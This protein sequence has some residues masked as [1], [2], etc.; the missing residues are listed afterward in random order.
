MEEVEGD[1]GNHIANVT[2][3]EKITSTRGIILANFCIKGYLESIFLKMMGK[4]SYLRSID[5]K[6]FPHA[7][8]LHD[9]KKPKKCDK[10]RMILDA[11]KYEFSQV[12]V[13]VANQVDVGKND[14]NPSSQSS[15][16]DY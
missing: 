6:K 2:M 3:E 16:N 15:K 8:G 12:T 14:W 9:A 7:I 5:S 1:V 10:E 11:Y 4:Y 13:N